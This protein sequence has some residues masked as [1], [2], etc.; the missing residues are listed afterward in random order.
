MGQT[1]F[2][3]ITIDRYVLRHS[4]YLEMPLLHIHKGGVHRPILFWLGSKGK[5]AADDWPE[6]SKYLEQGY[7]IVSIDPRGEGETRMRYK[8]A[9]Q[10]DPSL[11]QMDVDLAYVSPIS[12]VL[13][14]YVYNSVLIG[15]PYFLQ[16]VEDIEIATRFVRGKIGEYPSFTITAVGDAYTLANAASEILPDMK[17]IAQSEGQALNWSQLVKDKVEVWPVQYLIPGG[18]YI[19]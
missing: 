8:A 18:A 1:Q 4:E 2:N 7:D 14:D 17:L 11:A 5:V 10:D 19:H 9:S 3:D 6:L 16:M 13:A 15:R 12:G